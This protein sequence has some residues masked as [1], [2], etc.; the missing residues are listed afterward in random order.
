MRVEVGMKSLEGRGGGEEKKGMCLGRRGDYDASQE[1]DGW[2]GISDM[3]R[4]DLAG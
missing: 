1:I 2:R 3:R 4:L